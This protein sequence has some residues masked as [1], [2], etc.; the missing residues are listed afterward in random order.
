MYIKLYVSFNENSMVGSFY[1]WLLYAESGISYMYQEVSWMM[2][3]IYYKSLS[4]RDVPPFT[5]A[6]YL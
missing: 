2:T 3:L 6:T 4:V 1:L 5:K